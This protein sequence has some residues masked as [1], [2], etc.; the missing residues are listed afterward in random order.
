MVSLDFT[1][2]LVGAALTKSRYPDTPPRRDTSLIRRIA[3]GRFA[4]LGSSGYFDLT[5]PTNMGQISAE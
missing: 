4:D 3:Q 1:F 5:S 2:I